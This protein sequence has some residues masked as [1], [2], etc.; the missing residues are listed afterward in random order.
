MIARRGLLG[1]AIGAAVVAPAW[2]QMPVP[3][4][5]KLGFAVV[6][7]GSRIGQHL[8][9]FEPEGARLVVR[10]EV[11]ITVTFGP[12]T[13]YRYRHRARETWDGAEVAAFEAETNDDGTRSTVAMKREGARLAVQSSGS[14]NYLA[15]EGA[16][17]A[18]HWNRR[19]LQAPFVNTQTGELMRPAVRSAGAE[20][21]PWAPQRRG[22][23]M[24]M[25]GAVDMETWYDATP[26]WIGLRFAGR[27]GSI[28]QYEIL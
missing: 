1:A 14:G 7:N 13:L 10:V 21:L 24:V 22:E 6:R 11:D 28:I 12:I 23:R 8:L 20:A 26:G 19:M 25:S 17:P 5:R 16:L 27:D 2:A 9:F 4:G 3:A 15:P 18:T